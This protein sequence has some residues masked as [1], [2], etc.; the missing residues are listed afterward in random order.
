MKRET[1]WLAAIGLFVATSILGFVTALAPAERQRAHGATSEFDQ[2]AKRVHVQ[3]PKP[4]SSTNRKMISALP[5]ASS[6]ADPKV[7]R[8]KRQT[9]AHA[10][11]AGDAVE[12][13]IPELDLALD[14][15]ERN[16]ARE[17]ELLLDARRLLANEPTVRDVSARCSTTF[18]R[19]RIDR[20]VGTDWQQ[21]D[22]TLRPIVVGEMVFQ[23]KDAA[24]GTSLAFAYVSEPDAT[25]PLSQPEQ[26]PRGI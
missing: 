5:T 19:L 7:S 6:R 13:N 20:S 22:L 1:R 9:S 15:E 11:Y 3:E 4:D 23:T 17:S 2:I 12:A 26:E 18:C 10:V 16:Q 24:D 8:T 21:I 25:L 14:I